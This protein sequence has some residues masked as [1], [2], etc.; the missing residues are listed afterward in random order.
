MNSGSRKNF[1][2]GPRPTSNPKSKIS[3][4]DLSGVAVGRL[5]SGEG[6]FSCWTMCQDRAEILKSS[7][8][9]F[10]EGAPRRSSKCNATL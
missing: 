8:P 7:I 6:T 4:L 2:I 10:E 9:S 1:K 5:V 3:N